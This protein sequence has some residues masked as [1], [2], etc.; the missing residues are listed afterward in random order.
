MNR[1]KGVLDF[2][3]NREIN[4]R[5]RKK[6]FD[7]VKREIDDGQRKSSIDEEF[8]RSRMI[9]ILEQTDTSCCI[10]HAL[11]RDVL[12]ETV[13]YADYP[14]ELSK[15]NSVYYDPEYSRNFETMS[16]AKCKRTST[17][18][19]KERIKS[20]VLRLVSDLT[21]LEDILDVMARSASN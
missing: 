5:V 1:P 6:S 4:G 10:H 3:I 12:V 7:E 9:E 13:R 11:V 8:I 20:I 16:G 15:N 19:E 18:F 2:V 17:R 14:S 21:E